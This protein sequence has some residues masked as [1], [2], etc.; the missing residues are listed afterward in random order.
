[1]R[2]FRHHTELPAEARGGVI[3]LG[4]FDGVHLGHQA[5]IGEALRIARDAG[6]PCGVMTFEP[7]PRLVF[8]PTLPPFRLTPFRTKARY[9]EA[10]GV[11]YLFMQHF[12]LAFAKHTAE[13]FVDKVLVAGLAVGHVVVGYDYVFGHGRMGNYAVL[14][15]LAGCRGFSA[16]CVAPVCAPDSEVYSSTRVRDFLTAG[17]PA[18][19]A[20]LLGRCWEIEGRVEAGDRRGR[21][22]GFPTINLRLGEY[23]HPATGVYAVRAGVDRGGATVWHDG[24]ANFGNRPTFGGGDVLL[25]AHLFDFQGD[26]YGQ[27]LRVALVEYLRPERKFAGLDALKAQI[28][29]DSAAARRL[30]TGRHFTPDPAPLVPNDPTA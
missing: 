19:A 8:N 16:S 4:N 14:R 13:E 15:Q 26:L 9:I 12:D 11:D 23:L 2:I 17:R 1:M 18:D 27:H 10:L 7:H 25:E 21:T 20:R 5:V 29:E 6:A 30:L 28:A 22:I 24:V 3:A